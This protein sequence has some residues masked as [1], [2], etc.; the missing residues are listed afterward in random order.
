MIRLFRF[1]R[2][3]IGHIKDHSG[4]R[5][6]RKN[7][8]ESKQESYIDAR[9]L[10][11]P[12]IA[13]SQAGKELIRF[14]EL[15]MTTLDKSITA[16]LNKNPEM[17]EEISEDL[18]EIEEI[19]QSILEYL[20]TIATKQISPQD[21][22][23]VSKIHQSVNDFYRE[24]EI[25]D[26]MMKYT[27]SEAK[28]NREFTPIVYEQIGEL[29]TKLNEQ[30]S[31]VKT[32]YVE[33]KKELIKQVDALEEEIDNLRSKMIKEHIKRLEEGVCKPSNSGVYINLV[34][35]L[36]RAGDHLAYVAHSI[37]DDHSAHY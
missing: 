30:F 31:N 13:V 17:D 19:N 2:K 14:G 21:E 1:R 6:K 23:L 28:H 12:T 5:Q 3:C 11:T 36:E 15:C 32:M 35:N 7:Q 34:S 33:N 20:V 37:V 18:R 24:A 25:A 4:G 22:K 16:F 29:Q 26:N 8:K 10:E 27:K 9:F